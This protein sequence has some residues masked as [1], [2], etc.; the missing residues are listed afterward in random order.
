M[1][2]TFVHSPY[3]C[4]PHISVCPPVHWYTP[5]HPHIS[6][7]PHT[8]VHPIHLY[9]PHISVHCHISV[10]PLYIC[11]PPYI[12]PYVCMAHTSLY[13]PYICMLPIHLYTPRHLYIPVHLYAP[14]TSVCPL[15]I[16]NPIHP[17]YVCMAP[18]ISIPPYICMLP[19]YLYT[20]ICLYISPYICMLT[21]HLYIPIHLYAPLNICTP[22]Y[23]HLLYITY[24][25]VHPLHRYVLQLPKH[26]SINTYL[27]QL[28]WLKIQ[29][30]ITYKVATIMYKCIH[31]TAPAYLTE[32]V[33]S[34]LPH[35]RNLRSTQRGYCIQP[36]RELNLYIV[37]QLNRWDHAYG[38]LYLQM[39]RI[40]TT[41]MSSNPDLRQIYLVCHTNEL[42]FFCLNFY[43]QLVIQWLWVFSF[44]I[45]HSKFYF[46]LWFSVII[47]D[48]LISILLFTFYNHHFKFSIIFYHFII[49]IILVLLL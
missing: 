35:T 8:A 49:S 48:F 6:V 16:C 9:I 2:P 4:I 42:H 29:E 36:N 12:P 30:C 34:E 37:A 33:I 25:S 20:P 27:A 26:S 17:P 18:Y 24:M 15:Y 11:T 10:C 14:H 43:Y 7:W 5:I 40:A 13:P 1:I 23:I 3:I 47:S 21:I 41:L 28:H 39:S 19:I 32:M 22:P 46:C 38:T 31:N 45:L 44:I